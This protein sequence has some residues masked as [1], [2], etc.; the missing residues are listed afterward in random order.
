M[1]YVMSMN[2][3]TTWLAKSVVAPPRVDRVSIDVRLRLSWIFDFVGDGAAS[4]L[5]RL[6]VFI[7]FL[8]TP[9][10]FYVVFSL[11]VAQE[12]KV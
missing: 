8:G 7:R 10:T 12:S 2:R 11:R 1:L 9:G 6:W 5:R 4:Y 3:F